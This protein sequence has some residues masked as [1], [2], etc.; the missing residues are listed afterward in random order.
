M[1]HEPIPV[2]AKVILKH[3]AFGDIKGVKY[4][5]GLF[6]S[7]VYNANLHNADGRG[8][9]GY[10]WFTADNN[11]ETYD[12][13]RKKTGFAKFISSLDERYTAPPIE[14]TNA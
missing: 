14:R 8:D 13:P 5:Q 2:G 6:K 7:D 1:A 10:F 4:D 11:L 9:Q 12:V 3:T